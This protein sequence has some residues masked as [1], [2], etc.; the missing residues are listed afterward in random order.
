MSDLRQQIED[1]IAAAQYQDAQADLA[2]LWRAQPTTATAG[3]VLARAEQLRARLS[4]TP[5]RV[6]ILRSFTVEP[7]V[8][9]L[10]A[11]AFAGGIDLTVQTGDFNAYA[12]E[13]L[14]P[15]SSLYQFS[16]DAVLLAAQTRDI[17]PDL[18][19]GFS[20]L[21]DEQRQA[22]AERVA[23]EL[24]GLLGQL[25][26]NC[27]A[28]VVLHGLDAPPH[29]STDQRESIARINRGLR[30]FAAQRRGIHLLDY[31]E[32]IARF[33][34]DRWHDERRWLAMRLPMVADAML[35]LVREW[36]RYL[37]PIT[38]R[39]CKALVVDL[40]NT[41]W[42]GVIGEDGMEGIKL[43]DG[44]PGGAFQAVQRAILDLHRRGILIAVCSKNNA[45]EALV[46]IEQHPGM[47]LRQRHFAAMRINWNDKAESLRE[48]AGELNIGLDS[49]AFLDDNPA[50][51]ARIRKA[52]PEVTVIEPPAD[53]IGYADALRQ[54]PV[55]ARLTL[56]AE[57]RERGR[58]YAEQRQR[59]ELRESAASLDDY[60]RSL[61]QRVEIR[62]AEAQAIP[63][64]AQLTQKTNQFNLTTRRY[65]EQRIE[66]LA[67]APDSRVYSARVEDRFGD[68]GLVGVAILR[69]RPEAWEIDTF[70]L[71][72]RVIGR[73]IE[74]AMLSFLVAEA[75]AAG[76]ARMEGWFLP[77]K[78]N[79]PAESFFPS[80]QFQAFRKSDEGVLWALDLA[81]AEIACPEWIECRKT[82][83][84]I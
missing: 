19:E 13:I 73:T 6:A 53:P 39:I 30:E 78:K 15:A 1:A 24:E 7:L 9:L 66:E 80:H 75:R 76:A 34:R 23:T 3:Y 8:P 51:R 31:D 67:A 29:A 77:T 21:T 70:L 64:I 44:Y 71:S 20:S 46:A 57:D 4:L 74:T 33:G 16:A 14:D 68:H 25:R 43:D 47:L 58:Y 54:S 26:E 83:P 69:T 55:F 36:L 63:R 79:A 60:Y 32:V 49:L 82:A 61:K 17:A 52:L 11:A 81:T 59:G 50:E 5:C 56:T 42:G 12:R 18:W 22:A 72:C 40:D 27:P 37:H 38:G 35:P 2:E 62:L 45:A 28:Q 41:L 65:S 10:R 84:R 48:I